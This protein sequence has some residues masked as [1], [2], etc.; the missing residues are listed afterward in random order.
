MTV[1]IK[2]SELTVPQVLSL[3]I[4]SGYLF[5]EGSKSGLLATPK[6]SSGTN[7]LSHPFRVICAE[8]DHL[9]FKFCSSKSQ[10]ESN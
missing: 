8:D 5:I 3:L 4:K 6:F 10:Y 7:K 1:F 2:I 9:T